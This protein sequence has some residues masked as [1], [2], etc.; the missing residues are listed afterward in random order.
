M[1]PLTLAGLGLAGMFLLIALHVPIGVA[2]G[3]SGFI[4]VALIL[5][6]WGAAFTLLKDE[7]SGIVANRDLAVIPLFLL[8]GAFAGAAGLANR[9]CERGHGLVDTGLIGAGE[10][11]H[12]SAGAL[13]EGGNSFA[14]VPRLEG[15]LGGGLAHGFPLGRLFS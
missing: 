15:G 3:V 5:G 9:P 6:D 7:P 2:M 14:F 11:R 10:R 4:G 8:M 13:K 1:D 12:G